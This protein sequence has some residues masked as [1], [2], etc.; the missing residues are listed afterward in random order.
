MK[1]LMMMIERFPLIERGLQKWVASEDEEEDQEPPPI[2][3]YEE[4]SDG[5]TH[6]L[7][8]NHHVYLIH[9][10]D[11][12]YC[13]RCPNKYTKVINL[14]GFCDVCA[15]RRSVLIE[16]AQRAQRMEWY[17]LG[18]FLSKKYKPQLFVW[19]NGVHYDQIYSRTRKKG[20]AMKLINERGR[21]ISLSSKEMIGLEKPRDF[22]AYLDS[23]IVDSI[24]DDD[25]W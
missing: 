15:R 4:W 6:K 8:I 16:E 19:K 12:E 10:H 20:Q 5:S 25:R 11:S 18:F 21:L 9:N 1:W 24:E 13:C 2:P 22:W 3:F 17:P 7:R 14:R 23:G